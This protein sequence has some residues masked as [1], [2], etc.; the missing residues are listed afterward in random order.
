MLAL[1]WWHFGLI[2]GI[3]LSLATA[4]KVIKA[5]GRGEAGGA[6]WG[7]V[8][9]FA[10]VLFGTGFLCGVIVWAGRGL[11]RRFGAVG[12][13]IVGLAVMV[14]F[15]VACMLLFEPAMLGAR[16]LSGGAPM[17]FGAVVIGLVGGA[18]VGHD[19]R[20]E[21]AGQQKEEPREPDSHQSEGQDLFDRDDDPDLL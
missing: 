8:A 18:W 3:A 20:K 21:L 14:C 13:A 7:E 12:D 15:F 1:R 6:E 5:F 16:F 11:Y 19:L 4:V 9:V 17:L 10:P 2:G